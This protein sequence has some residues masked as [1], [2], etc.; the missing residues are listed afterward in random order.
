MNRLIASLRNERGTTLVELMAAVVILGVVSIGLF[1]ASLALAQ[2][3]VRDKLA[4]DILVYGQMVMDETVRSLETSSVVQA[5]ANSGGSGKEEL[6]FDYLGTR[7]VGFTQDTRFS[8]AS[9]LNVEMSDNQGSAQF[10]R[11]WP[12]VE[13]DRDRF[14]GVRQKIEIIDFK[15]THYNDRPAVD[16]FVARNLFEV[17][18]K[19]RLTDETLFNDWYIEREF[20]RVVF[21]PNVEIKRVRELQAVNG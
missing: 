9:E 10:L 20:K 4:N 17:Y 8:K 3:L 16:A 11:R 2:H 7:N 19:V 1:Q 15:M 18:L 14:D 13:L 6:E 21:T 5:G 12:P